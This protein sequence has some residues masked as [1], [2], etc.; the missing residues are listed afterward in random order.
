M[1]ALAF[2]LLLAGAGTPQ[3]P[4]L[5]YGG[6]Y[7]GV[8]WK[9]VL[10]YIAQ[11]APHRA[12][13]V[14]TREDAGAA[15]IRTHTCLVRRL[16]LTNEVRANVAFTVDDS[17]G[18]VASIVVAFHPA[19]EDLRSAL[20]D[21]LRRTYGP[22]TGADTARGAAEWMQGLHT[23]DVTT[24]PLPGT[25]ENGI[26]DPVVVMLIDADIRTAIDARVHRPSPTAP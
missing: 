7:A 4:F 21:S 1:T 14:A 6:M 13:C 23:M 12:S 19:R 17:S 25:T 5:Q 15:V 11:N 8:P 20:L 2:L 18:K 3:A 16:L 22:P 26:A 24:R 10:P 9:G